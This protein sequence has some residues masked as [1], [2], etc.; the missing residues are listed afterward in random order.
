MKQTCETCDW[1]CYGTHPDN[2]CDKWER[3]VYSVEINESLLRRLIEPTQEEV[4]SLIKEAE[5]LAKGEYN[6]AREGSTQNE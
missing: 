5:N 2:S 3:T 1:W 4:D 6:G